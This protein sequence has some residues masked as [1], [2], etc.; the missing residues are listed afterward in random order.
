MH[1]HGALANE[2]EAMAKVIR[3]PDGYEFVGLSRIGMRLVNEF[4][5]HHPLLCKP[6]QEPDFRFIRLGSPEQNLR[7]ERL[8]AE[9]R[10]KDPELKV[11]E[12]KTR[13]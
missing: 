6:S 13:K 5:R 8:I 4:Q 2:D 11:P 12:F 3:V 1:I 9:V 10:A 7:L